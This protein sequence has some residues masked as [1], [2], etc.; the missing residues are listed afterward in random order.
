MRRSGHGLLAGMSRTS[1]AAHAAT[2][3]AHKRDGPAWGKIAL[4]ALGFAALSAVWRYTPLREFLT[5]ERVFDWA[6]TFG[7][8]WWAPIAVILA[9]TPACFTMFPRPLITLFA[10][11][12][13]GPWLG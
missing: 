12:A 8:K 11:I 6:Q 1:A 7:S 10:V 3:R 13:F 9:Y 2:P 4:I 5:P